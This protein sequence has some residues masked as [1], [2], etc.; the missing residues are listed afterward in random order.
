MPGVVIALS[1]QPRLDFLVFLD[2]PLP[3][4]FFAFFEAEEEALLYNPNACLSMRGR[5]NLAPHTPPY[6]EG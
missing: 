5:S 1:N 3:F 2:L 4:G 6:T